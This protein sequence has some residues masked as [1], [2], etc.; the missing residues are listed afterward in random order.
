MTGS[1]NAV[2]IGIDVGTSGVRTMMVSPG[3]EV[4]AEARAALKDSLADGSRHE[5][6]PSDWWAAA[7]QT[8]RSALHALKQSSAASSIVGAAVTSTSGSLV[9]TDEQGSPVRPAIVYD[10]FRAAPIAAR[11]RGRTSASIDEVNSSYSLLKAAWVRE[12]EPRV[13]EQ[14]RRLLNP[15]DWIVGK[16]TGI[17]GITDS[18]S[19]LKLGYD[20]DKGMWSPAVA[21]LSLSSDLL[22]RVVSPG[23]EVGSVSSEA[24]RETGL[25]QGVPVVAGATDGMASLIA[26]GASEPGHASTTLGTTVVWKVLTESNPPLGPGMYCHWNPCGVWA[27]GAASNTGPGSFRSD[28]TGVCTEVMD[29]LGARHL[30]SPILCYLLGT[31]GERFPFL[32]PHAETFIEGEPQSPAG[33]H[34]AQLQ[35]LAF[36]ERWGYE[37]LEECGVPVG[38][39]VFSTGG[40][41]RS[42]VLSQLRASVLRRDVVRC[43]HATSAFGA[44]ILAAT[45]TLYGGDAAGAIRGMTRVCERFEPDRAASEQYE[46][47]Y[48]SFRDACARRGYV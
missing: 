31:R 39:N 6:N 45:K 4:L 41:A 19:A 27:P 29:R 3:G 25:P 43:K 24:S 46:P 9:L 28:D 23:V 26:S 37:R 47:I 20:V 8:A 14:V 13:W 21:D 48:R 5:Q 18:S 17:F 22:P 1:T 38:G 42:P 12:D 15:A 2:V 11:F 30:P 40:A 16:L 35:S 7:C 34:A 32:N 36:V 10:D 44:A 33:W